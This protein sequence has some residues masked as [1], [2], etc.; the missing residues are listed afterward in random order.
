MLKLGLGLEL[1]LSHSSHAVGSDVESSTD[2]QLRCPAVFTESRSQMID[3]TTSS[4]D[5]M[6]NRKL[7][8]QRLCGVDDMR[9][10]AMR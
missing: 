8:C 3:T 1:T 9:A 2:P 10:S 7:L 5:L 6:P 4:G